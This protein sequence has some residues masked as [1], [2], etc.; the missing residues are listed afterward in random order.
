MP[1]ATVASES[2]RR[3]ATVLAGVTF[4]SRRSAASCVRSVSPSAMAARHERAATSMR[5]AASWT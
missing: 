5:P 4:K 1:F 2:R 3:I